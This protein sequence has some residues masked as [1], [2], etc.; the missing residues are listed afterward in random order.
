MWGQQTEG[1]HDS[2]KAT[3][4]NKERQKIKK[5]KKTS[6]ARID[7]LTWTNNK[8][9]KKAVQGSYQRFINQPNHSSPQTGRA[10]TPRPFGA[11]MPEQTLFPIITDTLMLP[12]SYVYGPLAKTPLPKASIHCRHYLPSIFYSCHPGIVARC[13]NHHV[14]LVS[15]ERRSYADSILRTLWNKHQ[16][17]IY[18]TSVRAICGRYL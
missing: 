5:Q 7:L 13:L 2:L 10:K 18:R 11:T 17:W 9:G 1:R 14:P 4:T 6:S 15:Q 8:N 3:T 16:L 12:R